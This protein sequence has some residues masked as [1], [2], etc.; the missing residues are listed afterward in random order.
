MQSVTCKA[1]VRVDELVSATWDVDAV[2]ATPS[3]SAS[4]SAG[5]VAGGTSTISLEGAD[6]RTFH[7]RFDITRGWLTGTR[8]SVSYDTPETSNRI[9]MTVL[10]TNDIS[11]N[12]SWNF[13]RTGDCFGMP[14]LTLYIPGTTRNLFDPDGGSLAGS[15]SVTLPG[16]ESPVLVQLTAYGTISAPGSPAATGDSD[17]Y[18]GTVTLT[19][20]FPPAAAALSGI[21][22]Q[23]QN[24]VLN[25][26]ASS[27]GQTNIVEANSSIFPVDWNFVT[28]VISDGTTN[29][30]NVPLSGLD[31]VRFFRCRHTQTP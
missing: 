17:S 7:C 21:S 22:M 8:T 26:G 29:T 31:A 25:L 19:F 30:V 4:A 24:L 23:G 1:G 10:S 12:Y 3:A 27:L 6:G 9:V 11:L 16:N 18:S 13:T 28:N 14:Y 20:D 2:T 15:G 5:G